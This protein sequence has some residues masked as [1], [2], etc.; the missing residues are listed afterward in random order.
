MR[1]KIVHRGYQCVT[2]TNRLSFSSGL[3]QPNLHFGQPREKVKLKPLLPMLRRLTLSTL[4][5]SDRLGQAIMKQQG[6]LPSRRHVL[7]G[8][9]VPALYHLHEYE[10]PAASPSNASVAA[11]LLQFGDY[12]SASDIGYP[13]EHWWSFL[14]ALSEMLGP[15]LSMTKPGYVASRVLVDWTLLFQ[16]EGKRVAIIARDAVVLI[17]EALEAI[18]QGVMKDAGRAD[19]MILVCRTALQT[20]PDAPTCDFSVIISDDPRDAARGVLQQLRDRENPIGE[21]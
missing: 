12:L 19:V 10:T 21:I 5:F 14:R 4:D 15:P 20:A 3:A 16:H 8:V 9:Y 1:T 7:N 11:C 2:F 18:R 13:C 17:K 6:I